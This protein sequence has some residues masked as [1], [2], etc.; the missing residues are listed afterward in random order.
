MADYFRV[1]NFD[2][3]QHYKDRT[4]PWIKL[5]NEILDDYEFSCLQDASKLH[6]VLIWLL[7]SRT[8]NKIPLDSEWI[9]RKI[10]ATETVDLDVLLKAGFI[11]KIEENQQLQEAE[12][13]AS[14]TL[15]DCKQSAC[16]ETETEGER[17]GDIDPP[18]KQP[19]KRKT[20][21]PALEEVAAYCKERD[22]GIDP[23]RFIDHYEANGWMR[24]KNK[25]KD[26]KACV[27]TWEKNQTQQTQDPML[28]YMAGAR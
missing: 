5:Y 3:F 9:G 18:Q 7:A 23:Q 21:P 10:S 24:G 27:R 15:A 1:V 17:E 22:N 13:D 2:K 8:D 28:V 25:I 20:I 6:L 11:E 26:W 19:K 12:Q 16:L 4:P 14:D